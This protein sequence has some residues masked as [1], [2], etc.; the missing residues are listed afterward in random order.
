M[1]PFRPHLAA[2]L[3]LAQTLAIAGLGA[4]PQDALTGWLNAQTNLTT[5][6]AK[7]RQTRSLKSLAQ[8]VTT[9]GEVW[10]RAPDLFR[11]ELGQPARTIVVREPHRLTLLYPALKR[12]EIFPLTEDASGPWRDSLAL[13]EAGFPRDRVALESRFNILSVTPKELNLEVVLRPRSRAAQRWMQRI[14][15]TIDT[16]D[17]ALLATEVILADGSRLRNEFSDAMVNPPIPPGLLLPGIPTDYEV[18]EPAQP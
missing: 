7:V 16:R 10:F 9:A 14:E 12:A 2:T 18:V 3:S 8:P 17:Q 4:E 1:V 15:I 6:H 13:F 5:W 11:W